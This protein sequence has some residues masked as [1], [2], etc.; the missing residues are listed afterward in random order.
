MHA[1]LRTIATLLSFASIAAAALACRV[2]AT[3][4]EGRHLHCDNE[5]VHMGERVLVIAPHPDDE[6]LGFAGVIRAA[7]AA[8]VG[9]R[10]VI[11]TDGQG[12]CDACAFWKAGQPPTGES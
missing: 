8:G 10:V 6:V 12:H 9:V 11:V 4:P 5:R 3:A 1:T 2:P 7:K